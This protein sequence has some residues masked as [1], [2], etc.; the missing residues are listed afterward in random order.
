[1]KAR[2]DMRDHPIASECRP[3]HIGS[4]RNVELYQY[5]D[6]AFQWFGERDDGRWGACGEPFRIPGAGN[7]VGDDVPLATGCRPSL[8]RECWDVELYRNS[9][10]TFQWFGD[11]ADGHWGA[12]GEPF[13]ISKEAT[14]LDEEVVELVESK[15][16]E[17]WEDMESPFVSSLLANFS[18]RN[19]AARHEAGEVAKAAFNCGMLAGSK[20]TMLFIQQKI[21]EELKSTLVFPSTE[22]EKEMLADVSRVEAAVIDPESPM[23]GSDCVD[24]ALDVCCHVKALLAENAR[25]R[26]VQPEIQS[27]L[28]LMD[29]LAEQWGDEGVF[30]RCRDRLRALVP[31]EVTQ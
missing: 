21:R 31:T 4:C 7:V 10:G 5:V 18:R 11:R 2:S 26:D 16:S 9:D 3:P 17:A 19:G 23:Y 13:R 20:H 15:M 8:R 1:M 12:W 22:T 27:I 28:Q 30:R 25:L 14:V 6:G 24:W 29:G